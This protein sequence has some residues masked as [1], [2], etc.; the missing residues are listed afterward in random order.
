MDASPLQK[1]PVEIRLA[2]YE[3]VL[4]EDSLILILYRPRGARI[5]SKATDKVCNGL[6]LS[7]RHSL[8]ALFT[9]C[10][11]IRSESLPIFYKHNTFEICTGNYD[12]TS[13]MERQCVLRTEQAVLPLQ[14]FTKSLG[15]TK[16]SKLDVIVNF[17][18]YDLSNIWMCNDLPW[19]HSYASRFFKRR[20]DGRCLLKHT[21]SY[22][23]NELKP[24][25][26]IE[27]IIDC[28]N[29]CESIDTISSNLREAANM[30][31]VHGSELYGLASGIQRFKG[32]FTKDE[33]EGR[34]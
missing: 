10:K 23:D 7:T 4:T 26:T 19:L 28:D 2:T 34:W 32:D 14:I 11:E 27:M 30:P 9:T 21:G 25:G 20:F 13:I 16:P 5:V 17:G 3:L 6:V 1:L 29:I 18:T 31:G 12:M 33:L 22:L 8:C 15:S 24:A